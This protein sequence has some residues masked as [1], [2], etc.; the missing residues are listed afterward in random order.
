MGIRECNRKGYGKIKCMQLDWLI[1]A[2]KDTVTEY[3][4]DTLDEEKLDN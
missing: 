3:M 2:L 4:G 1:K